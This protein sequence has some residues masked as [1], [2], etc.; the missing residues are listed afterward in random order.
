MVG[1]GYTAQAK[2]G[3]L[4]QLVGLT[5]SQP[6]RHLASHQDLASASGLLGPM[7]S[8]PTCRADAAGG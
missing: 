5:P 6:Q 3:T 4:A 8:V 2:V 1:F 7:E